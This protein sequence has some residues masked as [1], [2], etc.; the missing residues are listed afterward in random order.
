MLRGKFIT[1]NTCVR[2][3]KINEPNIQ[4]KTKKKGE[5]K[6]KERR[7]IEEIKIEF[8]EIENNQQ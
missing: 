3:K 1:L 2:L 7:K 8:G 6:T 5:S 4:F